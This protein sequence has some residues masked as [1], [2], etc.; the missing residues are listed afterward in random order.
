MAKL[1]ANP[2]NVGD[3]VTY[4]VINNIIADLK[5]LNDATA[6]QFNLNLTQAGGDQ[7]KNIVSQKV[8]STQK[9]FKSKVQG[10][11]TQIKWDLTSFKFINAPRVWSQLV[12]K[13]TYTG[14]EFK[15]MIQVLSV[16]TT[17]AIFEVRGT[18]F[19]DDT[20]NI[21]LFAVEA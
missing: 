2:I 12:S 10:T 16:T 13:G 11:P 5:I 9:S 19:T 1:S 6:T 14:S 15:F 20:F 8:Y 7:S 17:Q 18:G 4:D 3:P 21:Y